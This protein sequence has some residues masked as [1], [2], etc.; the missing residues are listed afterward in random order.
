SGLLAPPAGVEGKESKGQVDVGKFLTRHQ[1]LLIREGPEGVSL[2][3]GFDLVGDIQDALEK[4]KSTREKPDGFV[5]T[6]MSATGDR[7]P[8]SG[9]TD[10][11]ENHGTTH[12]GEFRSRRR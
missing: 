7:E 3:N 10:L 1:S 2:G 6:R 12:P 8:V 11:A 5:S 4:R 9:L